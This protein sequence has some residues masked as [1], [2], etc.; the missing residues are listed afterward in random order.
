MKQLSITL[1]FLASLF[2]LVFQ[3]TDVYT[4][5]LKPDPGLTGAPG[6]STCA[7]AGCHSS[8][9]KNVTANFAPVTLDGFGATNLSTG[10]SGKEG[11]IL[12]L[13]IK[14]GN[15]FITAS[16]PRNGFSITALFEGDNKNVGTFSTNQN[17][18]VSI[19][20]KN[21]RSYAGHEVATGKQSWL[22]KFELPQTINKD[23]IF[24]IAANASNGDGQPTDSDQIYLA[25]YRLSANGFG[26]NDG[27]QT[28]V[29]IQNIADVSNV[30]IFPNPVENE[31]NLQFK[32][33]K[34]GHTRADIVDLK[35]ATVANLF[36]ENLN[37]GDFARKFT[38]NQNLN[39][40]IYLVKIQMEGK[41]Y[42]QKIMLQ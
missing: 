33:N 15:S 31:M 18:N 16:N 26:V 38:L 27:S 36:Q 30:N 8:T 34:G 28:P 4:H 20:S 29:G 35:G 41:T 11:D 14:I 12:N 10:Y 25:Q 39:S 42:F 3:Q 22:V 1:F 21:G 5:A 23:I 9:P 32:L 24:Y 6:E 17:Q 40:G 13:N 37:P 7:T 2:I 19:D